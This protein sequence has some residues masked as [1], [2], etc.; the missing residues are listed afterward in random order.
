[1]AKS[2]RYNIMSQICQRLK[3]GRWFTPGTPVSSTNNADCH[4]ITQKDV[5]LVIAALFTIKSCCYP[6]SQLNWSKIALYITFITNFTDL[7]K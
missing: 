2:T 5:A 3:T 7:I 1:M 4:D 6:I